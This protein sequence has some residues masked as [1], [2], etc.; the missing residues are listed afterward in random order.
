MCG[1]KR[2]RERARELDRERELE[3]DRE[4]E[5]DREKVGTVVALGGQRRKCVWDD[6]GMVTIFVMWELGKESLSGFF[7]ATPK[8]IMLAAF[9]C[10]VR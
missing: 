7:L 9:F 2:E 5:L 1:G 8:K 10:N 6:G 3:L 4:R